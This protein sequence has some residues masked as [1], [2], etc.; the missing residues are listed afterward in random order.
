VIYLGVD[1]SGPARASDTACAW[2]DR[3]FNYLDSA[4]DL[5]DAKILELVRSLGTHVVIG[6]DAPLSYNDGGGDRPGDKSLRK[7]IQAAGMR[8]GSV[9]TPT[10][11]R[12]GYLTLRGVAVSRALGAIGVQSIV[13]VHPGAVF[14]LHGAPLAAVLDYKTNIA[15]R[16]KLLD[17]VGAPRT[18]S[19]ACH[20]TA[21][22][23]A[24]YGAWKWATG[25]SRWKWPAEPPL[26]PFDFS[27]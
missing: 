13:E 15:S 6:L 16:K 21:A 23:G 27:C 26:H 11:T 9:M 5:S 19:S 8:G 14:A 3:D 25:A 10:M 1:L 20:L 22:C 18:L 4:S 24:A 17:W 12:M 7:T 2:F